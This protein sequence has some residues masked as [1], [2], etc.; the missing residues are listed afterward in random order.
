MKNYIGTLIISLCIVIGILIAASAYKY[1]YLSSE[2]ITVTGLAEKNFTSDEI[3][4]SGNFTRTGLDLKA[5]YNE[6]KNFTFY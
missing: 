3:V 6:L 4:W 1:K 2:T 5:S